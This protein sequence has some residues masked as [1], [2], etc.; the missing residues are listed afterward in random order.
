MNHQCK[1]LQRDF[2]LIFS[3]S[4]GTTSAAIHFDYIRS[5]EESNSLHLNLH[6]F[7]N[8]RQLRT[9]LSTKN[10]DSR[11]RG[12]RQNFLHDACLKSVEH[13][14]ITIA[15][16][17]SGEVYEISVSRSLTLSQ[18]IYMSLRK[19]QGWRI[20]AMSVSYSRTRP[21]RKVSYPNILGATIALRH[22]RVFEHLRIVVE[23][24]SS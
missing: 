14:A 16:K 5:P 9:C 4:I 2:C 10:A 23:D 8:I 7:E 11:S 19:L 6:N 24:I 13:L 21:T 12:R 22:A 18:Y 15:S 17:A 20:C 3:S 1:L